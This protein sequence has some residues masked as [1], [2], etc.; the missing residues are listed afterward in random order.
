MFVTLLFLLS[1][2]LKSLLF[3]ISGFTISHSITLTCGILG[4]IYIPPPLVESL[5]ALSILLL[6]KE[7]L[8]PQQTFT[9]KHLEL[10]AFSFG[11]LHGFGFSSALRDIGLPQGEIPLSLFCFNVGIELGQIMYILALVFI[12]YFIKKFVSNISKFYYYISY[13]IGIISTFWF[14]QRVFSF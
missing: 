13:I 6:A 9:K 5:I 7:M 4:I 8:V 10:V 11:L 12:L 2:N 1:K 14:I 3:T